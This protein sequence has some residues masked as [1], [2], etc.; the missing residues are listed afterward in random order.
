[1]ADKKVKKKKYFRVP[2]TMTTY[3][4][5]NVEA[6]DEDEAYDIAYDTDGDVF[7]EEDAWYGEWEINGDCIQEIANDVANKDYGYIKKGEQV[8]GI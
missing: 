8:N 1:M 4:H 5:I 7:V 6:C 2:A 3:L